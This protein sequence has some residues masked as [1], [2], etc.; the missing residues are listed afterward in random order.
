MRPAGHLSPDQFLA[1]A[2]GSL[3]Q[4]RHIQ[5]CASCR[6]E[7]QELRRVLERTSVV[8]VPEPSP[9]FW[10]HLSSRVRDAVAMETAPVAR[11][12]PFTRGTLA[13]LGAAI[14]ILTIGVGVTMRT[15]EPARSAVAASHEPV[16]K[17]TAEFGD[18][19]DDAAWLILGDVASQLDW[20]E[21]TEA[22]LL[23]MPGAA[24]RALAS[25]SEEEQEQVVKVLE[26]ELQ[27]GK[28]L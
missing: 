10:D 14:A 27:K 22:G 26:S 5:A 20:D 24:D 2:E 1:A 3:E 17:D 21:A 16:S 8:P 28:P 18:L 9:L 13:A 19:G 25:M 7:L 6:G 4:A 12:R 11:P 23:T 15:A